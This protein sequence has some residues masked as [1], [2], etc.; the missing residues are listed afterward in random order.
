MDHK[1]GI[2]PF[3]LATVASICFVGGLLVIS[4]GE[5]KN[6]QGRIIHINSKQPVSN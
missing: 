3:T 5:P 2:L 1:K 4:G 6:E